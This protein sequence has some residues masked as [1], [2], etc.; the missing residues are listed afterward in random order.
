MNMYELKWNDELAEIAQRWA[1]QCTWDHDGEKVF[2]W[3]LLKIDLWILATFL[4][5]GVVF[6]KGNFRNQRD[7]VLYF[8][9]HNNVLIC[10]PEYGK[11]YELCP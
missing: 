8:A 11:E 10:W 7:H 1:D 3:Q 4:S 2:C 5:L 9:G 6:K